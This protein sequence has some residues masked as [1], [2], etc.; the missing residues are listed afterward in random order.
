[1]FAVHFVENKTI[2]LTQALRRIPTV[3][4]DLKIKGRKGK[5]TSVLEIEENI[6]HVYVEFEKVVNKSQAAL[7]DLGKKKKR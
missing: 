7:N 5:V 2:V 1:M 6:F 3:D 4:E